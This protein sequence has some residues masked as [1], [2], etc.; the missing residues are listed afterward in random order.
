MGLMLLAV[1]HFMLATVDNGDSYVLRVLPALVVAAAG[2]AFSFTPTTLVIS[3]GI[4]ARNS[5]VSSGLASATAQIGGAIGIAVFGALDAARRAAVL[6]AGGTV[7]SAAEAGLQAAQLAAAIAAV[8]AAVI[9]VLLF[10]ALRPV[11]ARRR[12]VEA[13]AGG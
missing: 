8:V 1:A 11:T 10:P 7:L 12:R 9:A 4:A 2:V 5:G 13:D 3:E 6:E